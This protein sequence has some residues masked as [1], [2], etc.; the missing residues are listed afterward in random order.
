[1][2]DIGL[3]SGINPDLLRTDFAMLSPGYQSQ[4]SRT[5]ARF[6]TAAKPTH[7]T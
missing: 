5:M 4:F 1:M 2:P 3:V 7:S 6:S